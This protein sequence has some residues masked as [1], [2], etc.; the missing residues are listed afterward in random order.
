MKEEKLKRVA[1]GP[2]GEKRWRTRRGLPFGSSRAMI[3]WRVSLPLRCAS[4]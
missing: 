3:C 4:I 1:K 2:L